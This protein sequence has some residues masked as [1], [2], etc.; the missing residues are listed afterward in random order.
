MLVR[1][2]LSLLLSA[3]KGYSGRHK[4]ISAGGY[5]LEAF[6]FNAFH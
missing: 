6:I 5:I 3:H 4:I 2:A 1:F